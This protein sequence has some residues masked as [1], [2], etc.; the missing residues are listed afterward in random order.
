MKMDQ[1]STIGYSQLTEGTRIADLLLTEATR[2][3]DSLEL[4]TLMEEP[5][6]S[7]PD[8]HLELL[9]ARIQPFEKF[10]EFGTRVGLFC[11]TAG[12]D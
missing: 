11:F 6:P 1:V 12:S 2:I 5:Y 10:L 7:C 3:A 9:A 4:G 8:C